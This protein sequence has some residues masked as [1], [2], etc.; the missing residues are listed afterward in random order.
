MLLLARIPICSCN[1]NSNLGHSFSYI[2][3]CHLKINLL[4]EHSLSWKDRATQWQPAASWCPTTCKNTGEK[5]IPLSVDGNFNFI[6]PDVDG[7]SACLQRSPVL[8]YGFP[9]ACSCLLIW[10]SCLLSSPRLRCSSRPDDVRS[11]WQ[12]FLMVMDSTD[13]DTHQVSLSLGN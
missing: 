2:C 12:T 8:W 1:I 11:V 9:L 7:G 4:G 5:I 10:S 6:Y 3:A 13:T